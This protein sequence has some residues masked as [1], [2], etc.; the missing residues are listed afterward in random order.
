MD[1]VDILGFL[2]AYPTIETREDNL[3]DLFP[4]GFYKSILK[5]KE[6][7]S[8][9]PSFDGPRLDDGKFNP[10][11]QQIYAGRYAS[12]YTLN[13]GQLIIHSMGLGKTALA[14]LTAEQN[15]EQGFSGV[16]IALQNKRFKY[17]FLEEIKN[18]TGRKYYPEQSEKYDDSELE[19]LIMANIKK[20]YKFITFGA[21]KNR[22]TDMY[23]QDEQGKSIISPAFAE[24]LKRMYSNSVIIVDEAH[25]LRIQPDKGD[26]SKIYKAFHTLFH[27]LENC[28]IL[29]MTAT[30]MKDSW[31]EIAD[32]ANLILPLD[33]QLPNRG[34]FDEKFRND[35]LS[36]SNIDIL[37]DRLKGMVSTLRSVPSTVK[38]EYIGQ[39]IKDAIPEY[40]ER[41]IGV[42]KIEF[43]PMSKFQADGYLKAYTNDST[44]AE[45]GVYNESQQAV[46]FV[47]PNGLYGAKGAESYLYRGGA[48]KSLLQE[49]K[50]YDI[51]EIRP[52]LRQK[53]VANTHAQMIENLR[54]YSTKYAKTIE[55]ILGQY[56]RKG[57]NTFIYN[58]LVEGSGIF[59][60][61]RI[62]ELFGYTRSEQALEN[63]PGKRYVII[64]NHTIGD[65][66]TSQNIQKG[67]SHPRNARGEYVQVVLGSRASGEG[68]SFYNVEQIIVHTPFWNYSPIDQAIGRG[69]R[70]RSHEVISKLYEEEG[71]EFKVKIY[72]LAGVPV[73]NP[74]SSIDVRM[75]RI[76]E[77]KDVKIKLG[78]RFLKQISYDCGN[79][80]ILNMQG[81][82]YTRDCEYLECAYKCEG[83][84][85]NEN[86]PLSEIDHSTFNMYYSEDE[87]ELIIAHV[88]SIFR[89]RFLITLDEL[90]K[91]FSDYHPFVLIKALKRMIDQS[92]VINNKYGFTSYLR[93]HLDIYFLVDSMDKPTSFLS[94][95]YTMYPSIKRERSLDEYTLSVQSK[96]IDEYLD[97]IEIAVSNE[98]FEKV[99]SYWKLLPNEMQEIFIQSAIDV[100]IEG[101]EYKMESRMKFKDWLLNLNKARIHNINGRYITNVEKNQY[102]CRSGFMQWNDCSN[103]EDVMASIEEEKKIAINNLEFNEYGYYG[104]FNPDMGAEKIKN[105]FW[106]KAAEKDSNV[107]KTD[108]RKQTKGEKCASGT[109]TVGKL[110]SIAFKLGI[111]SD[112][113]EDEK[114][115]IEKIKTTFRGMKNFLYN[116]DDLSEDDLRAMYRLS[117]VKTEGLC[118]T[119]YSFMKD[120]NLIIT[121]NETSMR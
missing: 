81:V 99:L 7:N 98:E 121:T 73:E 35:G 51:P 49:K 18:I 48:Q 112:N 44:Q 13:E 60:F 117:K 40:K 68:F 104:I 96:K 67:V 116:V 59:L 22:F 83:I 103:D 100:D 30:P 11:A 80:R 9:I 38:R 56:S 29:L 118:D 41:Q 1:A 102:N 93:E 58:S 25:N 87:I 65:G 62:L 63:T 15:M 110:T 74:G 84:D 86:I 119:I 55:Y 14:I 111:R 50:G 23:I 108:K 37:R 57:G 101:T 12:Y 21:F 113:R 16:L 61:A 79:N 27:L 10:Q 89:T 32:L 19:K 8:L 109:L 88:R 5:K 70:Y 45:G 95:Y 85:D 90:Y 20:K 97:A 26:T 43:C 2:P 82:D 91:I 71:K 66:S 94:S 42:F 28:K 72:H 105:G 47:F 78:E 6:F 115:S 114:V 69:I 34:E 76:S 39:Y 33:K 17:N 24:Q 52:E 107:Q 3:V 36:I 77:D 106:I 53:I 54:V 4:D 31:L 64:T 92:I 75:Y 120:H 46:N